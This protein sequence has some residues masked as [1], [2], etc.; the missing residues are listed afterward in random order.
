MK[1]IELDTNR[2]RP[3]QR[4]N[5]SIKPYLRIRLEYSFLVSSGLSRRWA[6]V[7]WLLIE[8]KKFIIKYASSPSTSINEFIL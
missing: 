4:G 8:F 1:C 7:D 3:E 2:Q 6:S 5:S